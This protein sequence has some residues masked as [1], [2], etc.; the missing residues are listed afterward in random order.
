MRYFLPTRRRG[1]FILDREGSDHADLTKARD[2]A[3][4]AATEILANATRE[5]KDVS[6]DVILITDEGGQE[7]AK[8]RSR[9]SFPIDRGRSF[10]FGLMPWDATTCTSR[11][12]IVS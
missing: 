1:H 5:G 9:L 4:L 10:V 11:K 12:A 7:L 8:C 3:L 6:D 2:E